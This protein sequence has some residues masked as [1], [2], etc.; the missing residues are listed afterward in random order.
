[1]HGASLEAYAAAFATL[2]IDNDLSFKCHNIIFRV[3][4]SRYKFIGKT[5]NQMQSYVFF[6]D[7]PSFVEKKGEVAK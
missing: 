2:G 7:T 5:I 6:F 3:I 4:K 1:M